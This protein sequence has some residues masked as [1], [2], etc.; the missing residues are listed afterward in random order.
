MTNY[1]GE[2]SPS[3]R[4]LAI[5]ALGLASLVLAAL[6]IIVILCFTFQDAR[7]K[8]MGPLIGSGLIF[9]FLTVASVWMLMRLISGKRSSDNRT[10]MP[11]WFIQA[12]GI[13]F[14]IGIILA[15]FITR[16]FLFAFEGLSVALIMILIKRFLPK[17]TVYGQI[18]PA[19]SQRAKE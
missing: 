11:V 6:N 4:W 17:E 9:G 14:A 2:V 10:M 7:D 15:S 12:F 18:P 1:L 8:I 13:F 3:F 16:E 5:I 19:H